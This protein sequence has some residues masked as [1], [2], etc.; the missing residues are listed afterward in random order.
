[1]RTAFI[2]SSPQKTHGNGT[3]YVRLCLSI[4]IE[5]LVLMSAG[6]LSRSVFGNSITSMSE[7]FCMLTLCLGISLGKYA[8]RTAS[9]RAI[10][11]SQVGSFGHPARLKCNPRE[12]RTFSIAPTNFSKHKYTLNKCHLRSLGVCREYV[13]TSLALRLE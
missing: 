8:S 13:S 11:F 1:M 4:C 6:N 9:P 5:Q 12:P 7:S 10:T 3:L 2:I